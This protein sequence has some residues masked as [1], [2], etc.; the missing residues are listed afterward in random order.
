MAVPFR[1]RRSYLAITAHILDSSW[2]IKPIVLDLVRFF[3]S[4]DGVVVKDILSNI[5]RGWKIRK[6]FT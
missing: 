5:L 1:V 4:N 2:C 6:K 3:T